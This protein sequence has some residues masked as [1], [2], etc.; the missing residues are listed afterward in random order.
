M[1]KVIPINK[2]DLENNK[3][4][5]NVSV[6]DR[7]KALSIATYGE[8]RNNESSQINYILLA[9]GCR[10]ENHTKDSSHIS[11]NHA[12]IANMIH[13]FENK[14]ENYKIELLLVD[15]DAPLVEES[16]LLAAYIDY[17]TGLATTKTVNVI[18]LS[19]C[20]VMAFD[21]LKYLKSSTSQIKTKVY[22]VSSP[23]LGTIL[24][25]PL[26]LEQEFKKMVV[27]KLGEN[28]FSKMVTTAF[29]Q[30]YYSIM[31]NSHMDLDIAIPNSI[32][33][34][35][36]ANYDPNFLA[37][38]FSNSNI[39]S[40]SKVNHYENIC[41]VIDSAT[42]KNALRSG[43]FA[44]LGLCI[45]NDCLFAGQSDGM[46]SLASQQ[47][48]EDYYSDE[49]AKSKIINTT[50]G[51]LSIPIYANELLDIVDRNVSRSEEMLIR[52]RK[53]SK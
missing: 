10:V 44:V 47:K 43:N 33:S 28:T 2:W 27:A 7:K 26:L 53:R 4:K 17:L 1:G 12:G 41:T 18:G 13:Y 42:L 50:H 49:H 45:L 34:N 20:G 31:S 32:P 23:Y 30:L 5:N 15:N 19:K 3:W 35:L 29:M 8:I 14:K 11:D 9:D 6:E 39:A 40:I 24:A 25:S 38:I 37:N 22:S 16:R 51:A 21:M 48:I 46:V 52:I 36:Q